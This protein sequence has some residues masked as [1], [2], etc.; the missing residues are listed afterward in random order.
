MRARGC[1]PSPSVRSHTPLPL[2]TS[3]SSCRRETLHSH[4]SWPPFPFP[5]G[6]TRGRRLPC[7]RVHRR[8]SERRGALCLRC[9]AGRVLPPV[10]GDAGDRGG[11]PVTPRCAGSI[12]PRIAGAP[13]AA[14]A[15]SRCGGQR[16]AGGVCAGG[17]VPV[18]GV[19]VPL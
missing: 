3:P 10:R 9:R 14:E 16:G 6:G 5:R 15:S 19:L 18:G 4:S 2:S 8:D 1:P 13:G 11:E 7:L 12:D 17:G